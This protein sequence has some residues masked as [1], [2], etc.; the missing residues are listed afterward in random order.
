MNQRALYWDSETGLRDL[1]QHLESLGADLTGWELHTAQDISRYGTVIT[2]SGTFEGRA[3]AYLVRG[4]PPVDI[5]EADYNVDARVDVLDFLDFIDDF[6]AC[7]QQVAPCG[8]FGNPDINGDTIIDIL[9]FLDFFD[10][11]GQG[12]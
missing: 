3:R 5:C 2:G 6:A 11:F 12:C 8:S 4:L 1:R 9:D 10:A 7:D